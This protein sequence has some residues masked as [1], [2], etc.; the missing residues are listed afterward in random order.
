M[1]YV[2]VQQRGQHIHI[3]SESTESTRWI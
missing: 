1:R 3:A 2:S